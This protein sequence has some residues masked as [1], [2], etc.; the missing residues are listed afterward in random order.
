MHSNS[1]LLGWF[2]SLP[3]HGDGNKRGQ[4]EWKPNETTGPK[5][6]DRPEEPLPWCLH[7]NL[8]YS[9]GKNPRKTVF[10]FSYSCVVSEWHH[11]YTRESDAAYSALPQKGAAFFP[12][13]MPVP[14]SGPSKHHNYVPRLRFIPATVV[15]GSKRLFLKHFFLHLRS[16]RNLREKPLSYRKKEGAAR[17]GKRSTLWWARS[18]QV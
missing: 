15:Y 3:S 10:S 4:L 18:S 12:P 5:I 6:S 14:P 7:K 2:C 9:D 1:G 11:S 17:P 13:K 16:G 8:F